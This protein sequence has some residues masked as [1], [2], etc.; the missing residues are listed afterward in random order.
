MSIENSQNLSGGKRKVQEYIERI[1][2]GESK[3]SIMKGLPSSFQEEIEKGL[4]ESNYSN[5][6]AQAI[7]KGMGAMARGLGEGAKIAF[8]KKVKVTPNKYRALKKE[9]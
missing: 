9:V 7:K 5:P 8:K 2:S 6:T 4:E 1:K 3:E